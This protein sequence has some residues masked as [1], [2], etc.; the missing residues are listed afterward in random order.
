MKPVEKASVVSFGSRSTWKLQL[1]PPI[2]VMRGRWYVSSSRRKL[3]SHRVLPVWMH[4]PQQ[5]TLAQQ[6]WAASDKCTFYFCR[7]FSSFCCHFNWNSISRLP[8]STGLAIHSLYVSGKCNRYFFLK[9]ALSLLPN[10]FASTSAN[11]SKTLSVNITLQTNS[12]TC[13]TMFVCLFVLGVF[14]LL[15]LPSKGSNRETLR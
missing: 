13:G 9:Q 10:T 1:L 3:N 11:S 7:I 4:K 8:P 14:F 2:T 15:Q 5:T 12:N 6:K